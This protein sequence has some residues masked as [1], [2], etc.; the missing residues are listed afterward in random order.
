MASVLLHVCCAHCAAY[1]VEHWRRKGASVTAFWYNPNIHPRQEHEQRL[2]AMRTLA[3]KLEVPLI[4]SPGYSAVAYYRSIANGQGTRCLNCFK[5]RLLRT[6][7]VA[8]EKGLTGFTS[9]LLISPHQ[10]HELII[11]AGRD[12]AAAAG[13][14][15]LYEDLRKRYSDSRHITKPMDLY[16]QRYCGC[17][18]SEWESC[19]GADDM[20]EKDGRTR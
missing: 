16:R 4:V 12:A 1:C 15:F 11:E 7:M 5:L 19:S 10:E 2:G 9:T 6:A 8:Q 14:E 3:G 18:F 17:A 20:G 13:V